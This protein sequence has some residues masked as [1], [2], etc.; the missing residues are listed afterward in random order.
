MNAILAIVPYR[1]TFP[2]IAVD[3][4]SIGFQPFLKSSSKKV[5][6]YLASLLDIL[7]YKKYRKQ[8]TRG[9]KP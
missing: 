2:L 3:A 1:H 5:H 7:Y 4:H 6:L 8:T 9:H